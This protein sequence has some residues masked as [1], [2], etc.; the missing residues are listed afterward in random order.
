MFPHRQHY[1]SRL[2]KSYPLIKLV[3]VYDKESF[4]REYVLDNVFVCIFMYI[5]FYFAIWYAHKVIKRIEKK[6]EEMLMTVEKNKF[7]LD[8]I[9]TL[10]NKRTEYE[11][12]VIKAKS[13]QKV[14]TRQ[15]EDEMK[16]LSSELITTM[17]KLHDLEKFLAKW[18]FWRMHS[19]PTSKT[20]PNF[21]EETFEELKNP[22]DS[23]ENVKILEPSFPPSV[24]FE[25]PPR[26]F[27]VFA[28]PPTTGNGS[29]KIG[30][31]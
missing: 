23:L 7:R 29:S 9:V 20:M 28:R 27:G 19:D 1:F 17:S 16:R 8:D 31:K 3:D 13:A 2:T 24:P 22:E 26:K 5:L 15:L 10:K 25:P 18:R 21:D 6:N 12:L 30:F 14:T 11:N 4:I